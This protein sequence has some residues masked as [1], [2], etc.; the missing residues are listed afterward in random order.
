MKFE[1]CNLGIR[2]VCDISGKVTSEHEAIVP[3]VGFIGPMG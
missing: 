1:H 3:E 2:K